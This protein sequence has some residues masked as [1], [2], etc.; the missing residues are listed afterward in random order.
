METQF[1]EGFLQPNHHK[2]RSFELNG[3]LPSSIV[4]DIN[5]NLFHNLFF[6]ATWK[7]KGK[8]N[9]KLLIVEWRWLE[10]G[11]FQSSQSKY[12]QLE[13]KSGFSIHNKVWKCTNS[14]TFVFSWGCAFVLAFD[15]PPHNNTRVNACRAWQSEQLEEMP[16]CRP[17]IIIK[18]NRG[19][20]DSVERHQG[21][22]TNQ[23]ICSV[24]FVGIPHTRPEYATKYNDSTLRRPGPCNNFIISLSHVW[25]VVEEAG[26][27]ALRVGGRCGVLVIPWKQQHREIPPKRWRWRKEGEATNLNTYQNSR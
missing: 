3:N 16:T 2:T 7:W 1:G 17:F 22:S 23:P 25:E 14:S 18:S 11:Y 13:W 15:D 26:W 24:C 20:C 19:E 5:R 12:I 6:S 9:F 10:I 27:A 4:F 21:Q 8:N